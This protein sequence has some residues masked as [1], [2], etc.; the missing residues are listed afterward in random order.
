MSLTL[1]I[2]FEKFDVF[3]DFYKFEK[4]FKKNSGKF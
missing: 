3:N 2:S 4:V 1:Y